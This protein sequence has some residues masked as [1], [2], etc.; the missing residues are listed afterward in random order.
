MQNGFFIEIPRYGL[1]FGKLKEVAGV[2]ENQF[3]HRLFFTSSPCFVIFCKSL[4]IS[5]NVPRTCIQRASETFAVK[6]VQNAV[7]GMVQCCRQQSLALYRK[8]V[9]ACNCKG[10]KKKI[11]RYFTV[12][13]L[14]INKF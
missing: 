3:L 5:N 7:T 11:A 2:A 1:L 14:A 12:K 9:S 13:S 6:V 10:Y 8:A 4:I